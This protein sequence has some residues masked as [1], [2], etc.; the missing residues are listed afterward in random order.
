MSPKF[1]VRGRWSSQPNILR[2]SLGNG[3]TAV[4][5]DLGEDD[6]GGMQ[7]RLFRPKSSQGE[8][9]QVDVNS[10]VDGDF[11]DPSDGSSMNNPQTVEVEA[12]TPDSPTTSGISAKRPSARPAR[13]SLQNLSHSPHKRSVSFATE[14]PSTLPSSARQLRFTGI[15]EEERSPRK[16]GPLQRAQ[17]DTN[18]YAPIRRRSFMQH[19]I[20]TRNGG[21]DTD[22]LRWFRR[23][24]NTRVN[25]Q[26]YRG[27]LAGPTPN[28][29]SNIPPIA[30]RLE[31]VPPCTRAET[32]SGSEYGHIGAFKLGSLRIT[33][34][35]ASPVPSDIPTTVCGDEE[36]HSAS[37]GRMSL[38][39]D[40]GDV[41]ASDHGD[42]DEA[43]QNSW[44]PSSDSTPRPTS[45]CL[46]VSTPEKQVINTVS[47]R[48]TSIKTHLPLREFSL[49]KFTDSPTRPQ[50]PSNE[51]AQNEAMSPL[52]FQNTPP[53]S[54]NLKVQA[55]SKHMA[56][57]DDLFEPEPQTPGE[58]SFQVHRSFDSG[59]QGLET[60]MAVKITHPQDLEFKLLSKSDSGYS[61]NM[62]LRSCK[63]NPTVVS[64]TKGLPA[65][66]QAQISTA[67]RSVCY[68]APAEWDE[69]VEAPRE[70]NSRSTSIEGKISE[71]SARSYLA[72][73]PKR[74][75]PSSQNGSDAAKGSSRGP[76]PLSY[77]SPPS[78]IV[79]ER[80]S[81]QP[82]RRPSGQTSAPQQ[83]NSS[84]FTSTGIIPNLNGTSRWRSR[85][86]S[87]TRR[88]SQPIYTIQAAPSP[89]EKLDI[90]PVPKETS[91]R[92]QQRAEEYPV[93]SL[94]TS[95][96]DDSPTP[97]SSTETLQRV[98][99][100]G[101][102]EFGD[103]VP[104]V[105][106]NSPVQDDPY[107]APTLHKRNF[108]GQSI[109][110]AQGSKG[111]IDPSLWRSSRD[112]AQGYQKK[113]YPGLEV[114]D[115]AHNA[116]YPPPEIRYE[117][118]RTASREAPSMHSF[119]RNV[120]RRYPSSEF[121]P[122]CPSC[123]P[124]PQAHEW[125]GQRSYS[126]GSQYQNPYI[127]P[128]VNQIRPPKTTRAR[129]KSLPPLPISMRTQ[130]RMHASHMALHAV[131]PPVMTVPFPRP[132]E[133]LFNHSPV[134]QQTVD[135]GRS[136]KSFWTRRTSTDS[137]RS[138]R[139][140][141]EFSRPQVQTLHHQS[142]FDIRPQG[143][144]YKTEVF[145]SGP[146]AVAW[147]PEEVK[148]DNRFGDVQWE[149]QDAY[150][151][152]H[153]TYYY[154]KQNKAPF[155]TEREI[156]RDNSEEDPL[157]RQLPEAVHWRGTPTSNLLVP[158]GFAGDVIDGNE[159][160]AW[161]MRQPQPKRRRKSF[162]DSH[163]WGVA[164]NAVPVLLQKV[165]IT[166][167]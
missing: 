13:L 41:I 57:E 93:V 91:R 94:P 167:S 85:S 34:G 51:Y 23:S 46:V 136:R 56:V 117:R 71:A 101:S 53:I 115:T 42:S 132:G 21:M 39:S 24:S 112:E 166:K 15:E 60:P 137:P 163:A 158:N 65:P 141:M 1:G 151:E 156:E 86:K 7:T 131:I 63:S 3:D 106:V 47:S 9:S 165:K 25:A 18:L 75:F 152:A 87:R 83:S 36:Y 44:T 81:R 110:P 76:P 16:S 43:V 135:P 4:G 11:F 89:A 111:S 37:E 96:I 30:S 155:F 127:S 133:R 38:Q 143:A 22:P 109:S 99:S 29:L 107:A 58:P 146:E 74:L 2:Y 8:V 32:P 126:M 105:P 128:V 52:S 67:D 70:L 160:D 103:E 14:A 139:P 12:D 122:R 104:A 150:E 62:S 153:G 48:S 98:F 114:H 55:T 113:R 77:K 154:S 82:T 84:R 142:S 61:S 100:D 80:M 164:M 79:R 129:Q 59:Y 20:A 66:S 5:E 17:S 69:K 125:Y 144:R 161:N 33:N 159:T 73:R 138:A 157:H 6:T 108:S 130:D 123:G 72:G 149:R 35:A 95:W 49:F 64:S 92:L 40:E 119:E 90:P 148:F 50:T 124:P 102:V 120:P 140:S 45:P 31:V 68:S 28:P 54:P 134:H 27:S 147:S 162:R 10:D 78:D 88:T 118:G 26:N 97:T 145:E 19:G 121:R 116:A